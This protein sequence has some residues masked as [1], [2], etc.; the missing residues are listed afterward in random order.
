MGGRLAFHRAT[1]FVANVLRMHRENK[2]KVAEE[3]CGSKWQ[4]R[5]NIAAKEIYIK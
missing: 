2:K 5:P 4:K 1:K 3:T